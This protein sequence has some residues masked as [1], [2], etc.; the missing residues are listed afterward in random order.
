M[1]KNELPQV[2]GRKEVFRMCFRKALCSVAD[3][4]SLA[5]TAKRQVCQGSRIELGNLIYSSN[6]LVCLSN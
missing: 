3:P 1:D 5:P 6:G 2:P 4:S